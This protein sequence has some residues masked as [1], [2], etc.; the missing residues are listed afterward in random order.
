MGAAGREDLRLGA[1]GP[2]EREDVGGGVLGRGSGLLWGPQQIP[3]LPPCWA[4]F[5]AGQG[6]K[7]PAGGRWKA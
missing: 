5:R 4:G 2:W 6:R 3:P 7:G 1:A